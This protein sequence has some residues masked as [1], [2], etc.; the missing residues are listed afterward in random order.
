MLVEA[1]VDLDGTDAGPALRG[2]CS[3]EGDVEN[4]GPAEGKSE[5]LFDF[6]SVQ[7]LRQAT[8]FYDTQ[9]SVTPDELASVCEAMSAPESGLEG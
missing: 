2:D 5:V 7:M 9:R 4:W 3:F 6:A 1:V 8:H